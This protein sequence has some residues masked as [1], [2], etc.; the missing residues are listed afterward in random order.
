MCVCVR[1]CHCV[2]V[3]VRACVRACV[4]VRVCVER[5]LGYFFQKERKEIV[6]CTTAAPPE[7]LFKI[8]S[9]IP[10]KKRFT[11]GD[12]LSFNTILSLQFYHTQRSHEL[13]QIVNVIRHLGSP[14]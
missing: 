3:C 10:K 9:K 11:A 14:G 7:P 1:A 2:R 8:V 13:L 4:R 12:R 5:G 6:D